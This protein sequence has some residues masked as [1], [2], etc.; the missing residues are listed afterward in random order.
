MTDLA[1]F[2]KRENKRER[3]ALLSSHSESDGNIYTWI[4]FADFKN[5]LCLLAIFFSSGSLKLGRKSSIQH[6]QGLQDNLA[7]VKAAKW[8]ALI[9]NHAS[10]QKAKLPFAVSVV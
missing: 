2:G 5:T 4:P 10:N 7:L 3:E 9:M 8:K 6:H 1:V